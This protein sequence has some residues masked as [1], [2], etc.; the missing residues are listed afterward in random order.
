[1]K[2]MEEGEGSYHFDDAN[3][4][5]YNIEKFVARKIMKLNPSGE[6]VANKLYLKDINYTTTT[7]ASPRQAKARLRMGS[8]NNDIIYDTIIILN[9]QYDW[10]P[11]GQTLDEAAKEVIEI[12]FPLNPDGSLGNKTSGGGYYKRYDNNGKLK[13]ECAYPEGYYVRKER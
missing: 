12:H 5:Y 11:P 6:N 8:S 13:M 9:A 7:I 4:P 3:N 1:M 2:G 10:G